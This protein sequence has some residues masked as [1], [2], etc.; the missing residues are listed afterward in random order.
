MTGPG[1]GKLKVD[2]RVVLST[3]GS[4]KTLDANVY[5]HVKGYS[6]ARVT[7][8]DVE[9]PILNSILK[10]KSSTFLPVIGTSRGFIIDFNRVVKGVKLIVESE[11]LAN[12]LLKSG[13]KTWA[14]IGGKEGG[15]F[16]GFKKEYVEKLENLA[17]KTYNPK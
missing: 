1:I 4:I 9:S 8:L 2:A 3:L 11:T 17:I 6:Q 12:K 13:E 14:Y 7:H 16:V 10:P 5:I 15:I